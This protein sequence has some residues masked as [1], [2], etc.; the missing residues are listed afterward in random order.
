[1]RRRLKPCSDLWLGRSKVVCRKIGHLCS[2]SWMLAGCALWL[3]SSPSTVSKLASSGHLYSSRSALRMPLNVTYPSL[4]ITRRKVNQLLPHLPSFCAMSPP[5]EFIAA[6]LARNDGPSTWFR[7]RYVLYFDFLLS[8]L[9]TAA[10]QNSFETAL[11]S[12]ARRFPCGD[13][14]ARPSR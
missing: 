9:R 13:R 3:C 6:F 4:R 2:V 5:S 11:P 10:L 8:A 12:V 1:M 7:K 14:I